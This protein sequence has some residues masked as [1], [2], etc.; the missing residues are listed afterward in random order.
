ML[1]VIKRKQEAREHVFS[2]ISRGSL[3]VEGDISNITLIAKL[4]SY[5]DTDLVFGIV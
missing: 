4:I 5:K 1:N 3:Y 2:V